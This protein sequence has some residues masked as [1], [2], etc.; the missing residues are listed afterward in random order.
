MRRLTINLLLVPVVLLVLPHLLPAAEGPAAP[1]MV[2]KADRMDHTAA[3]D[4]LTASGKVEMTWQGMTMTADR[5]AYSRRD[6][7]LV[8]TG[9][10]T[11]TKG[12]DTMRGDRLTMDT[13]TGRAEMEHSRLFMQQG[14]I[15]A[16]GQ[17]IART[18]QADYSFLHGSITTCD[19]SVPS[20]RFGASRLDVTLD[21]YA[22]GRNVVFYVKDIPVFYF[23][24]LILP[25]KRERQTGLLFPRF[26]TSTKRGIFLDT[27]LYWAIS[28]SQEATIDLDIQTKRGVGVGADYRY[29]RSRNSEGAVGGYI[30]YDNNQ[31]RVRGQLLQSHHE[32]L[33]DNLSLISSIDW[34]SDRAYLQDY[35][36]KS[37]DYNRQYND[38]RIVL[39]KLWDNWLAAGQAIYTQ[40][41]DTGS[42]RTTLQRA[43]ELSLSGVRQPIPYLPLRLDL[44]ATLTNYYREQGMQ[45]ERAIVTPQLIATRTLF[46]GRLNAQMSGGAQIRGY[47]LTGADPGVKEQTAIVVPE[48]NAELSS[49][50]S[51]TFDGGLPGFS[52]LRHELAPRLDYRYVVDH[53][54]SNYPLFD[55][56]DRFPY[57]NMLSLELDS[58]LGGK[59]E[60]QNGPA[61]YRQLQTV[62]LRQGYSFG[63]LRPDPLSLVAEDDRPWSDLNLE[64]ETWLLRSFRLLADAGYNHYRKQ[65]TSTA[66]GG[67][68]NDGRGN[69]VG[70]SYRR[71]DQQVEYLEG[72]IALS[73]LRPFYVTYSNRYSFDRQDFL[74]QFTSIE[75]R[76][77]CWSAIVTYRDRPND[78]SWTVNVDLGGLFNS[79]RH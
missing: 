24:Y 6:K 31:H 16:T 49:S 70:A 56:S 55:Q 64:S 73:L 47:N 60:R 38:S 50:L 44:D 41:Y 63:G 26:G 75:Y 5:A 10:V 39:T 43:P 74:E 7:V 58:N 35:G 21:E 12:G 40:N 14:N 11:L 52:R 68:F 76:H 20:W 48:L 54:Q 28:P 22:T 9:N 23:P 17:R 37:G 62:R 77:Q 79:G 8:A 34:T 32:L 2:I 19:A 42:N 71:S 3:D 61:E 15:H 53:D 27:P 36:E 46:N 78:R 67:E 66:L 65:I 69:T 59:V 33:P 13:E 72:R 57:Q 29:L 45:G 18:G 1:G 4:L 51:R 25:V 30:I